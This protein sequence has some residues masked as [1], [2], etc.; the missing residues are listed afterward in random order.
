MGNSGKNS[1]TSQFYVT[2][3][4]TPQCDG[5][6]VIFGEGQCRFPFP[7]WTLN[8]SSYYLLVVSGMD[9]IRAAEEFAT[10]SGEPSVEIRITECGIWMPL[11][12]PANGYWF[13][14]PDPESFSGIT[15]EF[16]IEPRVGI[17]APNIQVAEKFRKT[18]GNCVSAT[19]YAVDA[20]GSD[21]DV[22]KAVSDDMAQFRLDLI[23]MAPACSVLIN[24]LEVPSSWGDAASLCKVETPSREEVFIEAKPVNVLQ[25]ILDSAWV[26]GLG[27]LEASFAR[28]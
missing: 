6:H 21:D 28:V 26:G 23:V 16:V 4:K 18:M 20:I 3:G 9:T 7:H 25:A 5:K 13:D 17:I 1:N 14:R 11:S 12:T 2:L 10:S 27:T 8:N 24:L 22:I 15:P 19:M